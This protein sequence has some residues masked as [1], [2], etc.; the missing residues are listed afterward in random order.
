[1]FEVEVWSQIAASAALFLVLWAILSKTLFEPFMAVFEEREAKTE[2]AVAR[3]RECN[4]E[5]HQLVEKIEAGLNEARL[6]GISKRDQLVQEAKKQADRVLEETAEKV[7]SE[8]S[9]GRLEIA[10]LKRKA[11]EELAKEVS[12]LGDMIVAQVSSS[13]NQELVH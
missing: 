9:S 11:S 2:G 10:A 5:N 12:S 4:E 1:M 6:E 7:N 13:G 8:L 3:A